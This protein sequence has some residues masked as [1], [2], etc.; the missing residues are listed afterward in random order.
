MVRAHLLLHRDKARERRL[1]LL[2]GLG[3]RVEM[4]VEMRVG[5]GAR[6]RAR[7]RARVRG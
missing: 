1:H 2:G 3:L 6:A 4:G 5:V 7:V